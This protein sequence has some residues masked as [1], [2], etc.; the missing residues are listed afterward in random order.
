VLP[1]G[2]RRSLIVSIVALALASCTASTLAVPS[3]SPNPA[4]TPSP[5]ESITPS[6]SPTASPTPKN[7]VDTV[8]DFKVKY[9]RGNGVFSSAERSAKQGTVLAQSVY[10]IKV[11]DCD[12]W[13]VTVDLVPKSKGSFSAGTRANPPGFTITVYANG[14]WFGESA[15]EKLI[16]MLHEWYHVV[17]H[18]L[19]QCPSSCPYPYSGTPPNWLI[20]GAAVYESYRAAESL[21]LAT[22]SSLRAPQVFI[23]KRDHTS[24]D[25]LAGDVKTGPEYAVSFLATE[26]LVRRGGS[27]ALLDFWNLLGKK[28]DLDG[29][30]RHA[31]GLSLDEFYKRFRAYRARGFVGS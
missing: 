30:F 26:Y 1:V 4:P 10:D 21:H 25:L 15:T 7:C 29:A 18:A 8:S 5:T 3:R 27:H 13:K 14:I 19:F 17:E 12:D 28:G 31:F 2:H 16:T 9:E 20:E 23:A 11:P 24:L 6:P 22:Y